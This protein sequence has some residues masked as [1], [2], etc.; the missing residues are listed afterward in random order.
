[1]KTIMQIFLKS[2]IALLL[3]PFLLGLIKSF[4]I[5]LVSIPPLDSSEI[6]FITGFAIF[7]FIFLIKS[8]PGQIYI[9]GHELTHALWAI[10]FKGKIKEFNVSEKSGNV[11]ITKTNFFISLAPYFFPIYTFLIIL[12]FYILALFFNISKYTEWLFL[13]VGITY[14][15]HIFLTAES[16]TIGQSDV[17][18]TGS[19]FSYII[20]C[21]LNLFIAIILFKF[22]SPEKILVK[23]YLKDSYISSI[24]FYKYLWKY[25]TKL[26]FLLKYRIP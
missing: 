23:Q 21:F 17:K 25:L 3:L 7:F 12:L 16:L 4:F 15:F 9:F 11:V 13:F 18:K 26:Y 20:I 14:S 19:I 5:L 24:I 22:I 8:L 1:M 10:F 6:W 2:V